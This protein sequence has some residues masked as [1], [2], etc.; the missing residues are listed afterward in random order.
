MESSIKH[1]KVKKWRKVLVM[2]REMKEHTL[3]PTPH[4][5]LVRVFSRIEASPEQHHDLMNFRKIGDDHLR[6][7][8]T[9]HILKHK[10]SC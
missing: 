8:I 10:C 3:F 6:Y 2:I 5:G 7:F 1:Q 4:R 9:Y